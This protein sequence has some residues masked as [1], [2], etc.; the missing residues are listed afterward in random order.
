M[1]RLLLGLLCWSGTAFSHSISPAWQTIFVSEKAEYAFFTINVNNSR[2]DVDN[3]MLTV[4]DFDT[5]DLVPFSTADRTYKLKQGEEKRI[6]IFFIN[7]KREKLKVCTWAK[8]VTQSGE[9]KQTIMSAV[10]S[11][12]QLQYYQ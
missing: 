1:K 6:R 11:G 4:E 9:R 8:N 5:G 10:C 12:V 2:S 3:F 7:Q